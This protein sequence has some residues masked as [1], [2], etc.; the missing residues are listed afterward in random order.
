[1][2]LA[3]WEWNLVQLCAFC[4]KHGFF[5][6]GCWSRP[7]TYLEALALD[8]LH[9]Y[10]NLGCQNILGYC[11]IRVRLCVNNCCSSHYKQ[12]VVDLTITLYYLLSFMIALYFLY[13]ASIKTKKE[14]EDFKKTLKNKDEIAKIDHQ[15][16]RSTR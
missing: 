9:Y 16:E 5:N 1:M 7:Q 15:K 13:M 12:K 6:V 2:Q 11:W 10:T 4:H 3:R 8:W 14:D